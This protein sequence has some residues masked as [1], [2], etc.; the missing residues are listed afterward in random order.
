MST[1]IE[2]DWSASIVTLCIVASNGISKSPFIPVV[3][4]APPPSMTKVIERGAPNLT[5]VP[6]SSVNIA[7]FGAELI[8]HH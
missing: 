3:I 8:T 2:P 6:A 5:S 4:A 7:S 1:S